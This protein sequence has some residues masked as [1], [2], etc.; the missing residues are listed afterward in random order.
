MIPRLVF[1]GRKRGHNL[2]TSQNIQ[3]A[4]ARFR[5]DFSFSLLKIKDLTPESRLCVVHW[6]AARDESVQKTFPASP[7]Q[8]S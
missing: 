3:N 5:Q 7:I 8:C 4:S 2:A 6:E 1:F